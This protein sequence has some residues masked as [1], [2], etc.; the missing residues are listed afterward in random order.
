MPSPEVR[1]IVKAA[2]AVIAFEEATNYWSLR[3]CVGRAEPFSSPGWR[4]RWAGDGTGQYELIESLRAACDAA[5][6][7]RRKRKAVRA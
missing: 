7:P 6:P 3:H 1:R 4:H 2:R 5:D